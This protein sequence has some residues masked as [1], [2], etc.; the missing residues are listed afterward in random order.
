MSAFF[1]IMSK[2]R[3]GQVLKRSG[4]TLVGVNP[5]APSASMTP[6]TDNALD[7]GS[8]VARWRDLFLSRKIANAGDLQIDLSGA[9][10]RLLDILNSTASQVANVRVDGRFS[11]RNGTL[12]AVTLSGTPTAD[13][14]V[15]FPDE[16]ITVA[17]RAGAETLTNKTL[18][19]PRVET[20]I[21]DTDGNEVLR[22]PATAAAVNDL[23]IQNGAT[24]NGPEIYVSGDDTNASLGIS[25]K[26][27][28]TGALKGG[29]GAAKVSW[30]DTGVAFNGVAPVARQLLAT[31]AGATVDDV[32][33]L[34]QNCGLARQS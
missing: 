3:D 29:S 25:P 32:I 16:D 19:S 15:T 12:F 30:N 6:A 28:G 23:T 2:L 11:F 8:A 24:G 34:L 20:A 31:G 27:T 18:G 22:T 7:L 26:G 1:E 4:K 13:R 17:S 33:T 14:T 10:T 21:L 9:A 5:S